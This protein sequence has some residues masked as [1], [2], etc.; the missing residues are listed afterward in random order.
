[1]FLD[2]LYLYHNFYKYNNSIVTN[3]NILLLND[4]N[5]NMSYVII[6]ISLTNII[7][8]RHLL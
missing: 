1:M 6:F 7:T 8:Q 2:V 4:I 3:I 5:Y